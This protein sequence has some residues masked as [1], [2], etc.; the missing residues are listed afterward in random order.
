MDIGADED[1]ITYLYRD[2]V[3]Q[4]PRGKN[5]RSTMFSFRKNRSL[6]PADS[7]EPKWQTTDVEDSQNEN[8]PQHCSFQGRDRWIPPAEL[9][10]RLSPIRPLTERE[11]V[12]NSPDKET[13]Y[14]PEQKKQIFSLQTIN[15]TS[16]SENNSVNASHIASSERTQG[17]KKISSPSL[18]PIGGRT[19][20]NAIPYSPL[21]K[22][23]I[24]PSSSLPLSPAQHV[25]LQSKQKAQIDALSV[26]IA[27][28]RA[29]L[30]S[31]EE[32]YLRAERESTK[33]K[34]RETELEHSLQM[35][36]EEIQA[37]QFSI[38]IMEQ[39]ILELEDGA[40]VARI[41]KNEALAHRTKK[42]KSAINKINKEKTDYEARANAMI[43][44]LNEQMASL[45]T[46]AMER[47]EVRKQLQCNISII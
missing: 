40:A 35:A 34:Q 8:R 44:Q 21:D 9:G 11:T 18:E 24:L 23:G 12:R 7:V 6:V 26:D 2:E 13:Q 5:R 16:N 39:R 22:E 43:M 37:L 28:L 30:Q 19:P 27:N 47:M 10:S 14:L 25:A 15:S 32:S 1:S 3:C 45:Q 29:I 41:E 17:M 46:V 36:S 20:L 38:A 31:K 42:Y 4:P 33:L